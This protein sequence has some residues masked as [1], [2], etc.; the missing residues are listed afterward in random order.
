[1]N[2][3]GDSS[4]Y[5]CSLDGEN[6]FK[7]TPLNQR[8]NPNLLLKLI[9]HGINPGGQKSGP[10]DRQGVLLGSIAGA[11]VPTRRDPKVVAHLGTGRSHFI[12]LV[13]CYPH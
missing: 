3:Q 10:E 4:S 12:S 9:H 6:G 11:A 2:A 7:R 8:I 1:M 5:S 13:V